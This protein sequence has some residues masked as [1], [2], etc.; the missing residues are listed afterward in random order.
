MV[1]YTFSPGS[2]GNFSDSSNFTVSPTASQ[3]D[4]QDFSVALIGVGIQP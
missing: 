1:T 4:G 2:V 3:S